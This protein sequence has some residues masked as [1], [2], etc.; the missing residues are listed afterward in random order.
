MKIDIIENQLVCI[1]DD[2][3]NLSKEE[4]DFL[5]TCYLEQTWVGFT[6]EG[7]LKFYE[8]N[9][10]QWRERRMKRMLEAAN[11][12]S[13]EVSEAAKTW[14]DNFMNLVSEEKR[15]EEIAREVA[16]KRERW[17]DRQKRG[18]QLC[19]YSRK[20]GD[21]DFWCEYSK[22]WLDFRLGECWDPV[23]GIMYMFYEIGIPNNHC[24][25]YFNEIDKKGERA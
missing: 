23:K 10:C 11:A 17:E 8:G 12:R 18:C 7:Y 20:F 4:H 6:E 14:I 16:L 25:D 21:G 15:Q 2:W 22:E 24:K 3:K 5:R 1:A 9:S 13:V 19:K